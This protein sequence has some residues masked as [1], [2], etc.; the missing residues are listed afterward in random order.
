VLLV[1]I[2]GFL[3]A[4]KASAAAAEI[5]VDV[6]LVIAVDA[7]GSIGKAELQLQ[8]DGIA[9]ALR[10]PI[11]QQAVSLGLNRQVMVAMLIWSDAGFPKHTTTWHLLRAPASFEA[12]AREVEAIRETISMFSVLGGGGTNIGHA[13]AYAIGMIE[14]NNARAPRRVVDISGDGPESRPWLEGAILLPE[15]RKIAALQNITVNGLAIET[16]IPGLSD[17]FRRNLIVG[18]GSFVMT[19][20]DFLDF[21]YAIRRKLLRELSP[22]LL[23]ALEPG[24]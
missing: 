6:E 23:G 13:L 5:E 10:D 9:A 17:W 22:A 7:S 15:A 19:A 11:V 16:D 4:P 14:N 12:L 18:A 8:L 1:I 21:K 20:R 24:G 2:A 3:W